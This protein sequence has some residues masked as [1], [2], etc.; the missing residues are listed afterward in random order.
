MR[1]SDL[2]SVSS[3]ATDSGGER[4]RAVVVELL[5]DELPRVRALIEHL[6]PLMGP[7]GRIILFY[8]AQWSDEAWVDVSR[9]VIHAVSGIAP[10]EVHKVDAAFAGGTTRARL[11]RSM[12]RALDELSAPGI[13]PLA[14]A[15]RLP[16]LLALS[17]ILNWLQTRG[18]DSRRPH[19]PCHG[20]SLIVR[21]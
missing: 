20:V 15:A 6:A 10:Q 3:L 1:L 21:T 8:K 11:E 13:R 4:P 14:A 9:D 12:Y 19:V 5:R 7:G 18:Y 2:L 16:V 17:A